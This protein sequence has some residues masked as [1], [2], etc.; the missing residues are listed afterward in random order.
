MSVSG[1]RRGPCT[2]D[3]KRVAVDRRLVGVGAHQL[4]RIF[5]CLRQT[6]G[7]RRDL[8]EGRQRCCVLLLAPVSAQNR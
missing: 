7:S 1:E 3:L 6:A 8:I 2:S 4:G 5:T